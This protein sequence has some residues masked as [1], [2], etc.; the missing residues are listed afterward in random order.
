[1]IDN[2]I[3]EIVSILKRYLSVD[4][5]TSN[6][7]FEQILSSTIIDHLIFFLHK[8]NIIIIKLL[9]ITLISLL[10]RED[11]VDKFTRTFIVENMITCIRDKNREA[12][13]LMLDFL[14]ILLENKDFRNL[15]LFLEGHLM[16]LKYIKFKF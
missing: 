14:S 1:M 2:I 4:Q 12:G 15:F 10:S 6:N 16:L 13:K 5:K 7:N 11:V 8:D 3:I 9:H